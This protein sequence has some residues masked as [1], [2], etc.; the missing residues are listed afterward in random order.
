[1]WKIIILILAAY[2]L[3]RMFV[4]DKRRKESAKANVDKARAKAGDLAKDPICGTYVSKENALTVR[5]NDT[6]YYFCSYDCRDAF[7][8]QK[9]AIDVTAENVDE[10][11]GKTDTDDGIE[12]KKI[13]VRAQSEQIDDQQAPET[14]KAQATASVSDENLS[15]EKKQAEKNQGTLDVDATA[16]EVNQRNTKEKIN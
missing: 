16:D 10:I 8:K 14:P 5:E 9:N 6:V 12:E 2:I 1:M 15:L 11:T 4:N 7:L 13:D 3:Y